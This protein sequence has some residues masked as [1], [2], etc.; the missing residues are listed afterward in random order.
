MPINSCML[1]NLVFFFGGSIF[2]KKIFFFFF[3]KDLEEYYQSV[4]RF[5][6]RPGP[7]KC[8]AWILVQIVYK[9]YQQMMSQDSMCS[10]DCMVEYTS[11]G[12]SNRMEKIYLL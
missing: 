12:D 4:K 8:W 1:G 5:D 10:H 9:A 3:K 2:L 6:S 11:K 7:T